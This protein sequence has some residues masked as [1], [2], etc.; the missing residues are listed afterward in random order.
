MTSSPF[1]LALGAVLAV[2]S[3]FLADQPYFAS[4]LAYGL[5]LG[6]FA[7]GLA[8]TLGR[9]GYVTF[10]HAAFFGLGAYAVALVCIEFDLSYWAVLP[11]ALV[12]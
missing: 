8:L 11:L 10:G 7:L 1:I 9:M 6:I 5:V 12:P 2:A 4:V 3:G